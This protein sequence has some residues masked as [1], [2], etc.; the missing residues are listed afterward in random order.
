MIDYND[1]V[2]LFDKD[3]FDKVGIW[4]WKVGKKGYAVRGIYIKGINGKRGKYKT[5]TMHRLIMDAKPGECVDHI[6]RNK[7]DNRKANLRLCKP[8]ENQRNMGIPKHNTS[9]YKGVSFLKKLGKWEAYITY[10]NKK[11]NL[12]YFEI[13]IEAAEAYNKVAKQKFG[14][15][16]V[17]N[18]IP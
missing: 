7:L 17:L 13:K 2:I 16:A 3:D 11:I 8:A 1:N 9:G 15:F 12:G 6:N 4:K 14:E 5:I 18:I 10:N